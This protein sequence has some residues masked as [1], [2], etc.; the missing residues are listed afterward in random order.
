MAKQ[1]SRDVAPTSPPTLPPSW[2]DQDADLRTQ[3]ALRKT[4]GEPYRGGPACPCGGGWR[5]RLVE[6][7]RYPICRCLHCGGVLIDATRVG[8]D[9]IA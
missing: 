3:L 7:A 9:G 4:P 2:A 1:P 5:Y 8:E 6:H